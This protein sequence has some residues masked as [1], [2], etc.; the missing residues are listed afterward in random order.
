[1]F[2]FLSCNLAVLFLFSFSCRAESDC[3][4]LQPAQQ[5]WFYVSVLPGYGIPGEVYQIH[6]DTL[7]VV[8][9]NPSLGLVLEST[10][11]SKMRKISWLFGIKPSEPPYRQLSVAFDKKLGGLKVDATAYTE[12]SVLV[13]LMDEKRF[14]ED[15]VTIEWPDLK[16]HTVKI[17]VHVHLHDIPILK[18]FRVGYKVPL[19]LIPNLD[20][21]FQKEGVL[22]FFNPDGRELRLCAKQKKPVLDIPLSFLRNQMAKQANVVRKER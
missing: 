3:S 8:W 10:T 14:F 9:E 7:A 22:Y 19:K 15:T 13:T 1:M 21:S 18:E 20:P 2:R 4:I 16:V 5:G 12:N 11:K 6:S 17:T